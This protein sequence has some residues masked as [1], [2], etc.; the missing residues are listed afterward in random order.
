MV[1]QVPQ[2]VVHWVLNSTLWA[3][4]GTYEE[5]SSAQY[6][7]VRVDDRGTNY[8]V[9]SRG[10][11]TSFTMRVHYWMLNP[12]IESSGT[13]SYATAVGER[14]VRIP[15]GTIKGAFKFNQDFYFK[16]PNRDDSDYR[17]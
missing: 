9:E 12:D 17:T 16:I 8:W 5:F 4:G 2:S 6:S 10:S 7:Y 3:R 1:N 15:A 13:D 11:T 14:I